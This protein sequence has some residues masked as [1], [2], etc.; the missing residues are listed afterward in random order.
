[1]TDHF[2][3]LGQPRRYAVDLDAIEREYLSRSRL[4]HP[5]LHTGDEQARHEESA[6]LNKA[7]Q[8]LTDPFRRAEY[9]LSL[10][11]GPSAREEKAQDQAFLMEMMELRERFEEVAGNPAEIAKAEAELEDRLNLVQNHVSQ[12]FGKV[13]S[14]GSVSPAGL[15]AIRKQLNA[16]KTLQSL[17]RGLSDPGID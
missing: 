8:T 4:V 1:M 2:D 17:L 14:M 13:E 12:L 6:E 7:Y 9:Y 11:G 5:D 10:L 3:R 16:A 15:L